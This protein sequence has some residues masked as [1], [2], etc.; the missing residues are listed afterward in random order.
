MVYSQ[1]LYGYPENDDGSDPSIG[2]LQLVRWLLVAL[3]HKFCPSGSTTGVLR[4]ANG[5]YMY[6]S[7]CIL[8]S[9][10]P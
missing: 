8:V 10:A 1:K 7:I 5:L 3:T 2:N 6:I 4:L 9:Q